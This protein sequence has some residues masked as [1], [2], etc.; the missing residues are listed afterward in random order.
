LN[1]VEGISIRGFPTL[2]FFPGNNKGSPID[3][4]GDRTAEAI[5]NWIKSKTTHPWVEG[6]A[7]SDNAKV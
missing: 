3:Y 2:K 7:S 6:G 5:V 4:D 1:E